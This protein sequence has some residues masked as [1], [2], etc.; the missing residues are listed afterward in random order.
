MIELVCEKEPGFAIR[1]ENRSTL[2]ARLEEAGLQY[3]KVEEP[4]GN[5][6]VLCFAP[7]SGDRVEAMSPAIR[8]LTL[9][10]DE[11]DHSYAEE[12]DAIREAY[13]FFGLVETSAWANW[14]R[15]MLVM[16]GLFGRS[17]VASLA[18]LALH[19]N[20]GL[21][22]QSKREELGD[23][24]VRFLGVAATEMSLLRSNAGV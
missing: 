18:G 12:A 15:G 17:D 2:L 20:T 1:P 22:A 13:G 21:Q 24:L 11:E 16:W 14:R 6:V 7:L 9:L 5:A 8:H 3:E 4:T 19:G 23:Q 10:V